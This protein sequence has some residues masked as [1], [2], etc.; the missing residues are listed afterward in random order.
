MKSCNLEVIKSSLRMG[1]FQS[2]MKRRMRIPFGSSIL[3]AATICIALLAASVQAQVQWAKR[4]ASSTTFP[5]GPHVGMS[6]DTNGNCYVTGWFD[7]TNDFGGVSLT[8]LSVGGSDI[9]VAKYNSSGVLQWARRAGGS[10]ANL[11]FGRGAGVDTNG[12]VY[13][14]GG[15]SGSADFGSFNLPASSSQVFFL[16]KYNNAGTVQWVQQGVGGQGVY[17]TELAVDHAG[18]SYALAFANNGGTI[19]FGS[20]NVPTPNDFDANFDASTILVKY[21]NAGTVQWATV[22][23]GYGETLANSVAADATGNVYVNGKKLPEPY[24]RPGTATHTCAKADEEMIFC[25]EGKFFVMGDNRDN[26]FDSRYYGPISRQNI[27]G[28]INP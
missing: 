12:N 10:P 2:D 5:E 20:T 23:G 8:N 17:G 27:L 25:G 7:G 3:L 22:M 28:L 16:A 4:I 6:L 26:S 15:V 24:L 1:K 13:V 11:N 19:T 21:D 14:T 9:F 18:N